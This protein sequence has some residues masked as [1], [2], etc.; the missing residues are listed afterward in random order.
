MPIYFYLFACQHTK[1]VLCICT[2]ICI[3]DIMRSKTSCWGN[4]TFIT[5]YTSPL[6]SGRNTDRYAPLPCSANGNE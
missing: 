5:H 4:P 2:Y 6:P 1:Y 3:S